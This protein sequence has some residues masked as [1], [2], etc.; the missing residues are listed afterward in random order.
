M[1]LPRLVVGLGNPG[2]EYEATR[3]NLGFWFVDQ[4]AR[5][6]NV[7][8]S[9]QGKFFGRVGRSGDLFLLEPT[10]Y[11]NC[12]GQSV[13]A[14]AQFYKILPDEILVVHDDLDLVPGHIRIKQGGGNGGHNGLRD[15]QSRLGTPDFWRLR[16]GIGHPRQLGLKQ[17]VVDFVLHPPRKEE[18]P[19]IERALDRCLLAWPQLAAGDYAAAQQQL[20]SKIQETP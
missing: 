8:L 20:H 3:H 5:M 17:P 19:E 11:M 14:L 9:A 10:V 6:L 7:T 16:L 1:T 4:L 15:I 13:L 18:L 2:P 12:S